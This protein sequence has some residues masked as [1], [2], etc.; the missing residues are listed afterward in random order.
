M[1]RTEQSVPR[2]LLTAGSGLLLIA[3]SIAALY[4]GVFKASET[5]ILH[6]GLVVFGKLETDPEAAKERSA[7]TVRGESPAWFWTGVGLHGLG[8]LALLAVGSV[9]LVF[10]LKAELV[11]DAFSAEEKSEAPRG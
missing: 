3:L 11:L 1:D 6:R 4:Q 10:G 7:I 5:G 2:R 8:G 9:V